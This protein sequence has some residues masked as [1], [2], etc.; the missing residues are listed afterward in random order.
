VS[1]FQVT[2][3]WDD[4]HRLDLRVADLLDQY[5]LTG[6]FYIA[7]DHLDERLTE[8]EIGALARRHEVGAHT[9]SHPVLT[10]ID[11]AAAREE[12]DGSRRW[13]QTITGTPVTAFCYPRGET[14]STVRQ[15]VAEAGFEVA[16]IVTQYRLDTGDDPFLLPTTLHVYPFPIRPVRSWRARFQPLQRALPHWLR[17]G[18]PL[19][20]LRDWSTLATTLLERAART[21]GVWHLWG[22]SWEIE[23]YGMWDELEQ[24]LAAVRRYPQARPVT[25]SQL[26]GE[27]DQPNH[28]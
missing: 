5:G 4:G 14:N 27:K 28:D 17:L 26:V 6:T 13:L 11:A 12:I 9:L 10:G 8:D 15:M 2:T 25:N 21:G 22:H 19:T 18:L 16:R 1:A 7:R 3:S 20:A 24:V 23:R